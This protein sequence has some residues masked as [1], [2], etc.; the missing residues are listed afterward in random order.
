MIRYGN[1][2]GD[3]FYYSS[4]YKIQFIQYIQN[5]TDKPRSE[6]LHIAYICCII[7]CK[8]SM[9]LF[10]VYGF[11]ICESKIITFR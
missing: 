3:A 2:L 5:K 7:K 10:C 8:K 11:Y 1:Y 6:H 9:N 4:N